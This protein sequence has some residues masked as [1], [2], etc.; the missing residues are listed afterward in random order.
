MSMF[1]RIR[2]VDQPN[3]V[4]G[5]RFLFANIKLVAESSKFHNS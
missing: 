2:T 4:T 3:I 1:N 5:S